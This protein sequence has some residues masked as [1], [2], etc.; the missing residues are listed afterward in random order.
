MSEVIFFLTRFISLMT[1]VIFLVS[2]PTCE[3]SQVIS[4]MTRPTS[5]MRRSIWRMNWVTCFMNWPEIAG[6]SIHLA[7]EAG[8]PRDGSIHEADGSSSRRDREIQER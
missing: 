3:G 1:R 6:G 8:H 5:N 2:E 7:R 4:L